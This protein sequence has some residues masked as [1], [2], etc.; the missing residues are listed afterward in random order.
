MT[1]STPRNASRAWLVRRRNSDSGVVMRMSGGRRA[2]ARR[3]SAGVSPVR[4]PTFTSR[5]VSPRRGA[6]GSAPPGGGGRVGPAAAG[7][8]LQGG[9]EGGPAPGGGGA[10]G[11]GGGR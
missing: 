10:G 9:G 1:V 3:S 2:N 8:G 7:R 11:G 4:M 5:T 6:A